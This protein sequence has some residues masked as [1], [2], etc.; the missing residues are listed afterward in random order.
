MIDR[1]VAGL[2]R[3]TGWL[4]VSLVRS[5]AIIFVDYSSYVRSYFVTR[6]RDRSSPARDHV[7]EDTFEVE[8]DVLAYVPLPVHFIYDAAGDHQLREFRV[9][10]MLFT[11]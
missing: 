8:G 11:P 1:R 6:A 5:L 10:S 9:S 3:A 2:S 4:P 7:A